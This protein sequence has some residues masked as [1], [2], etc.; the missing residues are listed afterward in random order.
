[1]HV[2]ELVV[3]RVLREA[4][5]EAAADFAPRVDRRVNAHTDEHVPSVDLLD[6]ADNRLQLRYSSLARPSRAREHL[7]LRPDHAARAA[8]TTQEAADD[9]EPDGHI[10]IG[11]AHAMPPRVMSVDDGRRVTDL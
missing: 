10:Q 3:H 2:H 6:I 11:A 8:E 1:M 7:C 5:E 4:D 9:A